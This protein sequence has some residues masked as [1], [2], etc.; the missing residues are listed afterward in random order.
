MATLMIIDRIGTQVS[1][2][3][4]AYSAR[5]LALSKSAL[6][7]K[8]ANAAD[9]KVAVE[10][11]ADI[12]KIVCEVEKARKSVKQP[13]LDLG[14]RIDEVA[15]DFRQDCDEELGR[16]AR[17]LG[18]FQ[19]LEAAR[20]RAA[21]QAKND[22]LS[23]IEKDR[24]AELSQAT[25]HEQVDEINARYN[26]KAALLESQTADGAARAQG[27]VVKPDWE[28]TV[29]DVW[30][31][32]KSHPG[33]VKIEPRISEIKSLLNNGVKVAG[34]NA[35]RIQKSGVRLKAVKTVEI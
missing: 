34:V 10:A 15:R 8:V 25:S 17:L 6:I 13:V 9:Q 31:L 12:Y 21:A 16:L 24:A 26:D 14:R 19:Q 3:P 27:Q 5:D 4:D 30:L 11:Q 33:C 35:V 28:V 2:S 1:I 23:H 18:D 32:A 22:R 29:T 20:V 7:G